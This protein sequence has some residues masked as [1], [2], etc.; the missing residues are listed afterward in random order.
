MIKE[1]VYLFDQNNSF[2][3]FIKNDTLCPRVYITAKNAEE[4]NRKAESI[5]IHFDGVADGIDCP[6]CGDRWYP[7]NENDIVDK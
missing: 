2:G 5:G 4:A 1:K 3:R 7:V 6:C